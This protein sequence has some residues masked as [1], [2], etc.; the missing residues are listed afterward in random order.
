MTN[1]DLP[2]TYP[3][4]Y[5]YEDEQDYYLEKR[6]LNEYVVSEV[7]E[8]ADL[9]LIEVTIRPEVNE[10]KHLDLILYKD[11]INN[12][13]ILRVKDINIDQI[14]RETIFSGET[15][16]EL[17]TNIN[18][19]SELVTATFIQDNELDTSYRD[20]ITQTGLFDRYGTLRTGIYQRLGVIPEIQ[21]MSDRLLKLSMNRWN[22]KWWGDDGI[23]SAGVFFVDIPLHNIP[24]NFELASIEELQL[25][26]D[27]SKTFG[28]YPIPEYVVKTSTEFKFEEPFYH[29]PEDMLE[30]ELEPMVF[31]SYR[32][33]TSVTIEGVVEEE[34]PEVFPPIG[35]LSQVTDIYE[36]VSKLHR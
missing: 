7:K 24:S 1:H 27:K 8:T 13:I 25:I 21:D 36:E 28:T 10:A 22:S 31:D 3:V 2:L 26:C 23:Y 35:F 19:N 20:T 34:Y 12:S 9:N 18:T 5:L 16:P 32:S 30:V 15:I 6:L 33:L 17:V 11:D 29:I 14:D 4:G